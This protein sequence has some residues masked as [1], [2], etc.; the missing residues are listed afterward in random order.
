MLKYKGEPAGEVFFCMERVDDLPAPP[1]E[2]EEGGSAGAAAAGPSNTVQVR[3][4]AARNL[5]N[6]DRTGTID[7]YVRIT[8]GAH[9]CHTATI[10]NSLSPT[11]E[12][13]WALPCTDRE[14]VLTLSVFNKNK[15]ADK[16]IGT[17][18]LRVE[19]MPNAMPEGDT[20]FVRLL[21]ESGLAHD[22]L[23]ELEIE[24]CWIHVRD[25]P[26][27]PALMST[28]GTKSGASGTGVVEHP[29]DSANAEAAA[30]AATE[31][32]EQRKRE[33]M[34]VS[35]KDG[36][37][38]VQVHVIEVRNLKPEDPN[39]SCDPI[40]YVSMLGKKKHTRSFKQ[41]TA[42]V[43][44]QTLF[45]NFNGLR[46]QQMEEAVIT[47]GVYDV[48]T[49]TRDDLIGS[50]QFDVSSVYFQPH[51]ELHDTWVGLTD[52]MDADD[53]GLQGYARVSV[54]VL[55]PGDK[56][57]VW[58]CVEEEEMGGGAEPQGLILMPP[59][60]ERRLQ[61]VV[62][63]AHEAREL[64]ATDSSKLGGLLKGGIDAYLQAEFA[65]NKPQRTRW[66]TSK[67]RTGSLRVEWNQE[68]WLPV[69]VP[70]M[71]DR[72]S[73][74]LWDYD[75]FKP[76]DRVGTV[77][78]SRKKLAK[79]AMQPTWLPIYGAPETVDFGKSRAFM[80]KYPDAASTYRGQL[81]LS[82]RIE[83]DDAI[84]AA[85]REEAKVKD[86]KNL[87]LSEMPNMRTLTLRAAI[88][89]GT[90]LP[91]FE[92]NVAIQTGLQNGNVGVEV[93]V[94]NTSIFSERRKP[95]Y[96]L[97][98]WAHEAE[99]T[100]QLPL[101][102]EHLPD[103]FVYL[104]R[105]D[106]KRESGPTRVC[107]ARLNTA[108][109]LAKGF[110]APAY[111]QSLQEDPAINALLDTETAGSVLIRLGLGTPAASSAVAADWRADVVAVTDLKPYELRVH[112]YMGRALPAAD[113]SGAL[114]PY[115]KVSLAGDARKTDKI[116]ANTNPA[117]FQ[118]VS[119]DAMLPDLQYAPQVLLQL[120]DW[121]KL[122]TDDLVS[123]LRFSLSDDRCLRCSGDSLPRELPD[124]Q[125]FPLFPRGVGVDGASGS[126]TTPAGH[127]LLTFQLIQKSEAAQVVP[128]LPVSIRPRY[129]DWWLEVVALGC[130]KLASYKFMPAQ[131]PYVELDTGD[132]SLT[133]NVK[134]TANSKK[135]S[136][137]N[138][139]FCERIVMPVQIPVNPLFA[140]ALS[141]RLFDSRLGGFTKPLLG[142]A[143]IPLDSKVPGTAKYLAVQGA[144]QSERAAASASDEGTGD[145]QGD[146][147][148]AAA[149]AGVGGPVDASAALA[150][151]RAEQS[152]ATAM[153]Q[154][155][156]AAAQTEA[157]A[158]PQG[159][160]RFAAG[161]EDEY[162]ADLP[163]ASKRDLELAKQV[164]VRAA[165]ALMEGPGSGA[166]S[167]TR[168][169][170]TPL[171]GPSAGYGGA[172]DED[173][174]SAPGPEPALDTVEVLD[175]GEIIDETAPLQADA[176]EQ[177][178]QELSGPPDGLTFGLVRLDGSTGEEDEDVIK[179]MKNRRIYSCGLETVLGTAPFESYDFWRGQAFGRGTIFGKQLKSTLRTVG[180][181]KGLVRLMRNKDEPCP[182]DLDSLLKPKPYV[183]RLY[184][185]NAFGV[186]PM[187]SSGTSDCYLKVKLGKE[188]INDSKNYI[189]TTTE[190]E[191]FKMYE[192]TATLPGASQL[193]VEMWDHDMI[194]SDDFIGRTVIDLEDRLFD[195]RWGNLGQEEESDTRYRPKPVEERSLWSSTSKVSQGT[196]RCWVDILTPA[197]A[198]RYPP[199][200]ISKPPPEEF[201]V[202]CVVWKTRG[203]RSS[204]AVTDMNDLYIKGWMDGSSDAV[205]STDIHW[206]SKRGKGSF[207][208]RMKWRVEYPN[209]FAYLTLQMWDKDLLKY[210][211][212]IC[213]GQLN[214]NRFL[215]QA[216]KTGEP[217]EVFPPRKPVKKQGGPGGAAAGDE[218]PLPEG[219][220]AL[221][222][223]AEQA[224]KAAQL[225]QAAE[226][227]DGQVHVDM[228]ALGGGDGA[229]QSD[230]SEDSDAD[231]E[232]EPE[233]DDQAKAD[234]AA[235]KAAKRKEDAKKQQQD[236][237]AASLLEA[238]K[239]L[240][241][242]PD[243]KP[244][245]AAW[246]K[247]Y[248]EY[249]D[250]QMCRQFAGQVL[251]SISIVPAQIA[252]DRVPAG[253]GR[254]EPNMNPYLP[255]PVGRIK[256]GSM[257]LN[258]L[259]CLTECLGPAMARKII[260]CCCFA[261]VV[262]LLVFGGPFL[263][264]AFTFI[265]LLPV[266]FAVA[267]SILLCCLLCCPPCY[268][269]SK[270]GSAG[271][272]MI[273]DDK[274]VPELDPDLA[275]PE[276][277]VFGKAKPEGDPAT[278]A[279]K[280]GGAVAPAPAKGAA[281]ATPAAAAGGRQNVSVVPDKKANTGESQTAG[282]ST[283]NPVQEEQD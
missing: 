8:A 100:V 255:E 53:R 103:T 244:D 93:R 222:T 110:S 281:A 252:R 137:T 17:V 174:L 98:S 140:P 133:S 267:V 196:L 19:D 159:S 72:I 250:G 234:A 66:V 243:V 125:W 259:Y 16:M 51:H 202:R 225:Q 21:A 186:Q 200:D 12:E 171:I 64:P 253:F 94:G 265:Q 142:T 3:V 122:G 231:T 144:V 233:E 1:A 156:A 177:M 189:P 240:G 48:D 162:D 204:D 112:A 168:S 107:Y 160:P 11:W 58:D 10:D 197:E 219:V 83:D 54:A 278:G 151:A 39:G 154:A 283:S 57:H 131:H 167:P 211:D 149:A 105:D 148:A 187:D 236:E 74:S 180:K 214:L 55:G 150:A 129:Q 218:Q 113:A 193:E 230:L 232:P 4:V 266:E 56:R 242:E 194:T 146:S 183:V 192:L 78:L 124:P 118:T 128:F 251:V 14:A 126:C 282:V 217:V 44:D 24:T 198:A 87:R 207:N 60:V 226:A 143:C 134:R 90:E 97:V 22:M 152:E 31:A 81:L 276:E 47:L 26:A 106:P 33:L 73:I 7:P 169:G 161:A 32:E 258:P 263:S 165:A 188:K 130:R 18:G 127:V 86:V 223:D 50:F 138:P 158:T 61:F 136:G 191:F 40:C 275:D 37:Y 272:K 67:G 206:R 69:M 268:Y 141:M 172:M 96:G 34:E 178:E 221:E 63:T 273:G 260:M 269:I 279:A 170:K 135:P 280:S 274:D 175:S 84:V 213:Q 29:E 76:D 249:V 27:K 254:K 38:Q 52:P 271:S 62:I 77:A 108:D 185:L 173:M 228:A 25:P 70:T 99:A 65:G 92:K 89:M 117:W 101:G 88:L 23:G 79:R 15:T 153:A 257:F 28:S 115:L 41:R 247:M 95:K 120:F 248:T 220:A 239:K 121:D 132:R 205:Q 245:N 179:Y 59:A 199:V 71:T 216:H 184:V 229:Y 20:Q 147:A 114:D 164:S 224:Q 261:G 91:K 75:R 43:F 270:Y 145:D 42:A 82:A 119:V 123:E 256:W 181:F 9:T 235:A 238:K 210:S 30:K 227:E 209:K 6:I 163:Q 176:R 104:Y 264:S 166:D 262:A 45:F 68:F 2:G 36:D 111:W 102:D 109:L 80:N 46:K 277:A 195:S 155:R 208:Y 13:T 246:L 85:E 49:F 139:N 201:E 116:L 237:A 35:F 212:C 5:K 241:I 157:S 182:L 190:P 215:R 203:V